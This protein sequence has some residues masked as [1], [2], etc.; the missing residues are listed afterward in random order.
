MAPGMTLRDP[1]KPAATRPPQPLR[2]RRVPTA[3]R[4][5]LRR[6]TIHFLLLFVAVV[7]FVDALV[8][9]KGLTESM[10]AR[11]HEAEQ[12]AAV[13]RLRQENTN[14][15]EQVRLLR[16]D[17]SAIEAVAREQLGLIRQGEMLFILKDVNPAGGPP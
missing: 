8:G 12:A 7:L 4:S 11:R 10:R 17:P 2:R 6:R 13:A 9:E 14:L 15:R 3:P 16:E 1:S 5:A